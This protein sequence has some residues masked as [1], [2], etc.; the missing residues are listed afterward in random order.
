MY[1]YLNLSQCIERLPFQSVF[2]LLM[3]VNDI[4]NLSA[5]QAQRSSPVSESSPLYPTANGP[6]EGETG[7]LETKTSLLQHQS[8][9]SDLITFLLK[10]H[11]NT[12]STTHI[13]NT[14][15]LRE[16]LRTFAFQPIF[17]TSSQ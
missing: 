7:G 13:T 12:L 11:N 3:F 17:P 8:H 5:T 1:E 14:N 4:S 9:S 2:M 6:E 15:C 10:I 16:H